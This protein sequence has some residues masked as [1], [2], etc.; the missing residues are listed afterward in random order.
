[1]PIPLD[2]RGLL[3]YNSEQVSNTYLEHGVSKGQC[4]SAGMRN[5]TNNKEE[6]A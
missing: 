4:C 2:K 3:L 6:G 1:M 5:K